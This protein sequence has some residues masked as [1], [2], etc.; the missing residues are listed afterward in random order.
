[1]YICK[2]RGHRP[3]IG[4]TE[5]RRLVS[6]L[7]GRRSG[8]FVT[9]TAGLVDRERPRLGLALG[10]CLAGPAHAV[11]ALCRRAA[12]LAR[13]G[14]EALSWSGHLVTASG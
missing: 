9:T 14:G 4:E 10:A 2:I 6:S 7:G 11:P 1:M 12:S 5:S 8:V 13:D 3:G